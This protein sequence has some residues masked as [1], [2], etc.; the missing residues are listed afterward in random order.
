ML[1]WVAYCGFYLCRKNFSVLMPYLKSEQGYS[2]QTLADV[3]FAYSIAYALGQFVTGALSDRWGA[4][5]V[6]PAGALVSAAASALTGTG[7]PLVILQGSNG[8][9]QACGWPGVLKL[10]RD[11]FPAANRGVVMAWWGTHLVAGGFIATNLAAKASE[12]DWRRA[13]WLPALVLIAIAV[14][15]GLGVRDKRAGAS[16]AAIA[17]VPLPLSGRLAAIA[18]MYFFVKMM[19][20]SFLF[21]LPLY[22]TEKLQYSPVNAGYASSTF[23]FVGFGGVLLAGY[24]SERSGKSR[25]FVVGALMMFA[26][27]GACA[28]YPALSGAGVWTNMGAIALVGALIFGPDTLMAGPATLESVP[29]EAAARAAGFVNGV[30][31]IGQVLSPYMVAGISSRFGWDV[32]FLALSGAALLGG[33]AL[34]TQWRKE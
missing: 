10:T 3:L 25:R 2:S 20:Y 4:R 34:A 33:L 19:R 1:T 9:A 11:W 30:G 15:F 23:E 8:L 31:S 13:A 5:L 28:A 18:V 22:M 7:A 32:L 29:P 6:V 16:M 12:G 14:A 17:K 21:W 24:L 26:L 27:A